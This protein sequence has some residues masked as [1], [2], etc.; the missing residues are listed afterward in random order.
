MNQTIYKLAH[1][2]YYS[3]AKNLGDWYFGEKP[4][5]YNYEN[6][7]AE[8]W[9]I[10][11]CAWYLSDYRWATDTFKKLLNYYTKDS[12]EV[13]KV[14]KFVAEY[15]NFI[16]GNKKNA[17]CDNERLRPI[18]ERLNYVYD[19][20]TKNI[21]VFVARSEED[22]KDFFKTKFPDEEIYSYKNFQAVG[23]HYDP[24]VHYLVFREDDV[25]S[26]DDTE[27]LGL[28]A[29]EMA[30]LDL[31]DAGIDDLFSKFEKL[32]LPNDRNKF[33]NEHLTDLYVISKGYAY[34]L[35]KA[36]LKMGNYFSVMSAE[37]IKL[38]ILNP[39]RI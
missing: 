16:V 35:Y 20:I 32:P 18:I 34:P 39:E 9:H 30:H 33:I 28:C 15:D 36:R 21:V 6:S 29:H 22:Y 12:S 25:N 14:R 27:L 3:C 5:T 11:V 4:E 19:R 8:L 7:K 2:H 23:L 13:T 24:K 38:C 1:N 17:R 37:E 31:V 10:A 26:L